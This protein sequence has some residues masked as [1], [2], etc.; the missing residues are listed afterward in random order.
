MPFFSHPF[1]IRAPWLAVSM[2]GNRGLNRERKRPISSRRRA[3]QFFTSIPY[4]ISANVTSETVRDL[5]AI[6]WQAGANWWS[7]NKKEMTSVS[8]T[9]GVADSIGDGF[10]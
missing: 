9:T 10:T 4:S 1:M 6:A 3:P 2:S 5:P 8:T 7:L